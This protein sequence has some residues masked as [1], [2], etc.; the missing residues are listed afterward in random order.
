MKIMADD[1]LFFYFWGWSMRFLSLQHDIPWIIH[2]KYSYVW[3]FV[4]YGLFTFCLAVS[5]FK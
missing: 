5:V 2:V 3:D 1:Y 4:C